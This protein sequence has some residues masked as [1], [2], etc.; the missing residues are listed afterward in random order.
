MLETLFPPS[1]RPPLPTVPTVAVGTLV[2]WLLVT[3]WLR[4]QH[5]LGLP[6]TGIYTF[7]FPLVF[8]SA[9]LLL[10]RSLAR[11]PPPDTVTTSFKRID[12]IPFGVLLVTFGLP[13]FVE[14]GLQPLPGWDAWEF[15]AARA[16]VWFFTSDLSDN[17]L[18]R[19]EDYPPAI[20]LMML[21][22][23]RGAHAWRDDLFGYVSLIHYLC[24]AAIMYWALTTR[25]GLRP[26]CVGVFFAL[27]AP[28]LAVHSTVGGYADLTVAGVLVAGASSLLVLRSARK[29]T[30]YALP[31]LLSFALPFYKIPGLFWMT[32]LLIGLGVHYYSGALIERAKAQKWKIALVTGLTLIVVGALALTLSSS[33][34]TAMYQIGNY[35]LTPS[36]NNGA[37]F[38]L[39]ELLITGS[40]L[41]LWVAVAHTYFGQIMRFE[42]ES[43]G[44]I[45][46]LFVIVF[47]GLAFV[48]SAVFF[49]NTLDWWQDGSTLNRAL[50]HVA[51][52]AILLVMACGFSNNSRDDQ[53]QMRDN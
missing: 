35:T 31:I 21:W 46:P 34:P 51:P 23:A 15:W 36:L 48:L 9:L 38:V 37:L 53:P 24:A 49:S 20:S 17:R 26:A 27:G 16:K 11:K 22:V 2:G 42:P 45:L 10:S 12:W 14:V 18:Q 44:A 29:L 5:R 8:A 40:F 52:T 7:A 13:L 32:I 47:L 28:L 30:D 3:F 41:G 19:N 39:T 25:F 6:A 1:T 33:Q 43:Y 4:T 50:I